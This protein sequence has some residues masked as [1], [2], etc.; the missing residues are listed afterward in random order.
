MVF[1][2]AGGDDVEGGV[3]DQRSHRLYG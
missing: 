1:R 3:L 2:L